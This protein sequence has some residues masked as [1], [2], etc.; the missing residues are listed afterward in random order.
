M[1]SIPQPMPIPL[2]INGIDRS[3]P[4]AEQPPGTTP[5][6]LNVRSVDVGDRKRIGKRH[7]FGRAFNT[8]AGAA[9]NRKV[10]GLFPLSLATGAL[11]NQSTVTETIIEAWASYTQATAPD[12][13][14]SYV[15][16]GRQST[17]ATNASI[18]AG[19][20]VL[21]LDGGATLALMPTSSGSTRIYVL[22]HYHTTNDMTGVFRATANNSAGGN[23]W[24]GCVV[25]IRGDDGWANFVQCRLVQNGAN[26]V[27]VI[28][29]YQN[30]STVTTIGTSPTLSLNNATAGEFAGLS[31]R[32]QDLGGTQ[33]KVTMSWPLKSGDDAQW[34]GFTYTVT[35]AQFATQVRAGVAG[36]VG[37]RSAVINEMVYTRLRPAASTVVQRV[38]GTDTQS[39]L[40][41]QY[42]LTSGWNS[43][44]L[45]SPGNALTS[46]T[47][48]QNQA[49]LPAWPAIDQV[50]Q[51]IVGTDDS[52]GAAAKT[53]AMLPVTTPGTATWG[54]E[55]QYGLG[56]T[57]YN[58]L[59]AGLLRISNDFHSCLKMAITASTNN[60]FSSRQFDN[61]GGITINLW[62]VVAGVRTLINTATTR[63]VG[64]ARDWI[65]FSD[66][67]ANIN[68]TQHGMTLLS[69]N[70][71]AQ[72]A[73]TSSGASAALA[74]ANQVGAC[75]TTSTGL[76]FFQ[77]V[78]L[79]GTPSTAIG[80]Y[81][82]Q[83]LSLTA[84]IAQYGRIDQPTLLNTAVG[85][86]LYNQ[87]PSAFDFN[88]KW[89]AV[90]GGSSKVIDPVAN[91]CVDWLATLGTFPAGCQLAC[92]YRGRA[93]LARQ[94]N[95][96]SIWYMSRSLNMYDWA[97]GSSQNGAQST[98]AIA[99]TDPTI[100]V[101]GD[102]I[103]AMVGFNE[104]LLLM[105]CARSLYM[106]EGD[107]GYKGAVQLLA[108]T[109]G[110]VGPR[111]WCFD[112]A[113]NLYF[114]G[115][116]GLYQMLRGTTQ[117]VN[118]DAGRLPDVLDHINLD[119]TL[120]QLVFDRFR[121]HVKIFLTPTDDATVGY[122]TTFDV[123]TG[124]M[125]FLDQ[126]PLAMGPTAACD[127]VGVADNDRRFLLGGWDG[128]IR[129]PLDSSYADD[130]DVNGVTQ[131][132]DSWVEIGPFEL[133]RGDQESIIRELSAYIGA[134][135]TVPLT[136]YWF[137]G[138]DPETVSLQTFSAAV[139]TGTWGPGSA[140]NGNGYQVNSGLRQRGGSHKIRIRYL[141]HAGTWSVERV[142]AV[143]QPRSRRR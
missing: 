110:I 107:P 36:D 112:E 131:D 132:I 69:I 67:G 42:L 103:T 121:G 13:L 14:G 136:W 38:N 45:T 142:W 115:H 57:A 94:A 73:W 71:A 74:N 68:V 98:S 72:A 119:F 134:N 138:P 106:I 50:N 8:Q 12:L 17:S 47:G 23:L 97:I 51:V 34:L 48:P 118:V 19:T 77:V 33:L 91:T 22:A 21:G 2:P 32:L 4:V 141:G 10:T 81:T 16:L 90:D 44:S 88:T 54:I 18:G 109:I 76:P 82:A 137:T 84:G 89:Y 7:G 102:A 29:E 135:T 40:A 139:A 64:Y 122:H 59:P 92:L 140:R 99:G 124:A 49:G 31:I 108:A 127:I 128:Y 100:G 30:G 120:I 95:N 15:W 39:P 70:Y 111:A 114:F 129:R 123:R 85:T 9:G 58:S 126:F 43:F 96:P 116:K 53:S 56:G 37:S 105:G 125:E 75:E 143:I 20:V 27:S 79:S 6:A 35:S 61:L 5:Y 113:G 83:V 66:D 130:T 65:R 55:Y 104:D 80:Q 93:V 133:G 25:A 101:P 60:Q 26:K 78:L 52:L 3:R 1:S 117:P 28:V 24:S 62:A 41:A 63:Y 86:A 46:V 11:N 87:L